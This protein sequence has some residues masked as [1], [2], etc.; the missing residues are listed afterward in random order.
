MKTSTKQHTVSD[1]QTDMQTLLSQLEAV[2]APIQIS[3]G[4]KVQAVLQDVASYEKTQEQLALLRVLVCGQQ[5][6]S[7]GQVMDH[8]TFFAALQAQDAEKSLAD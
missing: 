8:D 3:V 5:Q 4:G 7:A 6:V 2:Q 1:L